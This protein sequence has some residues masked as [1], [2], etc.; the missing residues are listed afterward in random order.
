[1]PIIEDIEEQQEAINNHISIPLRERREREREN[2]QSNKAKGL[3]RQQQT[4]AT[5]AVPFCRKHHDDQPQ[6]REDEI[7]KEEGPRISDEE[8]R[9]QKHRDGQHR[10][11]FHVDDAAVVGPVGEGDK[12]GN[13]AHDDDGRDPNQGVGE[14]QERREPRAGAGGSVGHGE[15]CLTSCLLGALSQRCKFYPA[16]NFFPAKANGCNSKRIRECS[17]L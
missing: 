4:I 2:L 1:M 15:R 6:V 7:K 9:H 5:I 16:V 10:D 17:T 13:D 12:V 14:Y 3:H 8:K 11:D